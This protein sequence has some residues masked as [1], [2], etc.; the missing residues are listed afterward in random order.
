[1]LNRKSGA[2]RKNEWE[3]ISL[4]AE[5][6]EKP[7]LV[8]IISGDLEQAKI[9]AEKSLELCQR[10]GN[11][12]GIAEAQVNG[13]YI[14][15]LHSSD[16]ETARI[17]NESNLAIRHELGDS[18]KLAIISRCPASLLVWHPGFASVDIRTFI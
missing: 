1:M 14:I 15:A 6:Y 10:S 17:L 9:L 8:A 5:Y 3:G 11:K 4:L 18:T 13:L 12:F 7:G 2:L 16:L